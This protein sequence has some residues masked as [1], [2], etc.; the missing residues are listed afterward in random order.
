[1]AGQDS[2]KRNALQPTRQRSSH[3]LLSSLLSLQSK[4]NTLKGPAVTLYHVG[5]DGALQI[6]EKMP[7]EAKIKLHSFVGQTHVR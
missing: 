2:F 6:I 1:M 7:P 4:G 5:A 3:E